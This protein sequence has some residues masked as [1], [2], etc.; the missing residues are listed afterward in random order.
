MPRKSKR[1]TRGLTAIVARW[2]IENETSSVDDNHPTNEDANLDSVMEISEEENIEI[3]DSSGDDDERQKPGF[4]HRIR[5][6]DICDL[7][8]LC[9][10]KSNKKYLS[11]LLYFALRYFNV[12]FENIDIFL[13]EIGGLSAQISHKWS[14]IFL[15]GDFHQ[16]SNDGRGGKRYDS[17]YD[18]YPDIETEAKAFVHVECQKKSASFTAMDVAQFIDSKYYEVIGEDKHEPGLIRSVESCRIDLR[19][20]GAKFESNSNRPY[21]EGHN[22][23]DVVLHRNEFIDHFMMKKDAYYTVTADEN[24][25]WEI[26]NQTNRTILIC[27]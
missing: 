18:V 1:R 22:R 19:H 9:L 24:P 15:E 27:N 3:D 8:L 25:G 11:V 13:K 7:F 5:I 4:K 16:F 14:K 21:F 17:F 12:S 20:W 6:H 10:E 26:P 23:A 2:K